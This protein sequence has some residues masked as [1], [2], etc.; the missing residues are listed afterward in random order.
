M[1][2]EAY[3]RPEI[4]TEYERRLGAFLVRFNDLELILGMMLQAVMTGVGRPELGAKMPETKM[5]L[6]LNY[7]SVL[8]LVPA[9]AEVT[10]VDVARLRK[11]NGHR[12]DFAHGHFHQ[13][14]IDGSF[15][16]VGANK[17][18]GKPPQFRN[19][20]ADEKIQREYAAI[21]AATAMC[22]EAANEIANKFIWSDYA[23]IFQPDDDK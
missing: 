18:G 14:V 7:L 1:R 13:N 20:G 23:K 11:L 2:L 3:A 22:G 9:A 15:R 10:N 21:D 8:Q 4:K 5:D 12:N 19:E 6:K 16:I 17:R